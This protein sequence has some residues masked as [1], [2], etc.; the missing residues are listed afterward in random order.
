MGGTKGSHLVTH[1]PAL[2]QALGD[3]GIYAE[4]ED[5]RPVFLLPFAEATLIGTTDIPYTKPPETAVAQDAEIDYLLT[6]ANHVFPHI[7]LTRDDV[8]LHYSGVRPLPYADAATPAAVTRRHFL[9]EHE[10][11][12]VPLFSV[13]GGKLTT[14]RSLA[15]ETAAR[16][17]DRLGAPISADS[18]DRTVPGGEKYPADQADLETEQARLASRWGYTTAQVNAA[19]RLYGTMAEGILAETVDRAARP[20]DRQNLPDTAIPCRLVRFSLA[21]EW[22]RRLADVVERR[23]LLH[24]HPSLSES[25]LRRIA[26]LMNEAQLLASD[27]IDDEIQTCRR[28]LAEHYGKRTA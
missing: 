24:F 21:R 5:G 27:R 10:A 13:I 9:K 20:D 6:A 2:R 12:A 25:C 7:R 14:C 8:A 11:S 4:A 18:R 19:W 26:E 16:V 23:L 15:E 3:C 22:P 17:L 28:R 1:Q